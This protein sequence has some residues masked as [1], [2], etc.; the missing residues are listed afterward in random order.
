MA[1][2]PGTA[3]QADIDRIFGMR[4]LSA[5]PGRP[6][7]GVRLA[8]TL[9]LVYDAVVT[10]GGGVSASEAAAAVGISRATAQRYLTQLE[11]SGLVRLE[12]RYG[13]TGRPEHRYSAADGADR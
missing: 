11:Q 9:R 8:P 7:E 5:A 10:A 1:E 2:L 3:S 13:A 4:R 6:V 12:L